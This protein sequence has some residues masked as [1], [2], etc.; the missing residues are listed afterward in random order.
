MYQLDEHI[1]YH[2]KRLGKSLD[3]FTSAELEELAV[4]LSNIFTGFKAEYISAQNRVQS[5]IRKAQIREKAERDRNPDYAKL[6]QGI[7]I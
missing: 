7:K 6:H 2:A 5:R 3:D 4:I 1:N